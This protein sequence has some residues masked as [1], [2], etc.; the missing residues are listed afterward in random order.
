MNVEHESAFFS[1]R[2][3]FDRLFSEPC[4]LFGCRQFDFIPLSSTWY[5]GDSGAYIIAFSGDVHHVRFLLWL[6]L[7]KDG[8]K[9]NKFEVRQNRKQTI[10]GVKWSTFHGVW[11]PR[12]LH[13]LA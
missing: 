13:L 10:Y 2:T 4:D 8:T 12:N 6:D 7:S 9:T 5:I 1:S 3:E 11:L